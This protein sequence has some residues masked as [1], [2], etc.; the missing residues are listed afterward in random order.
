MGMGKHLPSRSSQDAK[1]NT[2]YDPFKSLLPLEKFQPVDV[3]LVY[4]M[5]G[6]PPET[7]SVFGSAAHPSHRGLHVQNLQGF[8][9]LAAGV[10]LS[11]HAHQEG[12]LQQ[13]SRVFLA[14]QGVFGQVPQGGLNDF[15]VTAAKAV[16]E[17]G[18]E[19]SCD[20]GI[21]LNGA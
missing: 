10:H 5:A 12:P 13:G 20:A 18:Q 6:Q 7:T 2:S 19:I 1:W 14:E 3:G 11:V 16:H 8:R 21:I 17:G 4:R 9:D 15:E